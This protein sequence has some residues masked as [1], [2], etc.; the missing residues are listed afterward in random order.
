VND[1]QITYAVLGVAAV[2]CVL[3]WLLLIL[4]P[5]WTSYWRL[6]ERLL[7]AFMSVYILVAFM[8]VGAGIGGAF[9]WYYDRL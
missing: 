8:L 2:V 5:A 7:A 3:A 4:I 1:K 9:L 6:R